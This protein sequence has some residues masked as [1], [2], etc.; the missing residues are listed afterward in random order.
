[1][2]HAGQGM[3]ESQSTATGFDARGLAYAHEASVRPTLPRGRA[4]AEDSRR[5]AAVPCLTDLAWHPGHNA[6][7]LC[8]YSQG[9]ETAPK[10]KHVRSERSLIARSFLGGR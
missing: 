7:P 2:A 1:M 9:E 4:W 5:A 3:S 8:Q 10:Q 6:D